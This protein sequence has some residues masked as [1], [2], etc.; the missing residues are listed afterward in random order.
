LNASCC[1]FLDAPT[2][3]LNLFKVGWDNNY[4]A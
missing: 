1:S 3:H 2:R 4:D